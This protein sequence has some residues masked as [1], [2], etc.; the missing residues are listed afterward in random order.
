M[1]PGLHCWKADGSQ[2]ARLEGFTD[3][4]LRAVFSHDGARVFI[5]DF[6]G[7]IRVWTLKDN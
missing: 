1:Q 5:G 3:L 2:A 4:P 7:K 6:T